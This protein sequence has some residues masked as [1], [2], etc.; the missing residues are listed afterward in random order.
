MEAGWSG[1][2]GVLH[3]ARE[4]VVVDGAVVDGGVVDGGVFDGGTLDEAVF[5]GGTSDEAVSDSET[6]DEAAFDE[7]WYNGAWFEG[8]LFQRVMAEEPS[9]SAS[10]ADA[11]AGLAPG[12]TADAGLDHGP[13]LPPDD[14]PVV[15]WPTA[16]LREALARRPGVRLAR[17]VTEAVDLDG[18]LDARRG[19][20]GDSSGGHPD[21]GSAVLSDLPDDLLGDLVVACGRLQSWAAGVQ[22]VVVAERAARE[23]HPL[24][25]SSLVAQVSGELVVTGSEASEVVVRGESGADHPAVI[26]ALRAGR[27]DTRKAQTLLRSATQLTVEERAE[28]IVRYLP[29]APSRTWRWLQSKMLA[30]AKSRH[31]ADAAAKAAV[32]RRSVQVDRAENDMAWLSA[33]LPAVDAT[34]VWGVVDDMARQLRRVPGEE[35]DLG[36][37]RADCLT[38]IVTGR[39]VPADRFTHGDGSAGAPDAFPGTRDAR[40]SQGTQGSPAGEGEADAPGTRGEAEREDCTCGGRAPVVQQVVRVIPTRPV[41]RVTVPA[42]VLLGLDDA[43]ADLAGFGPLPAEVART[44]A[45]DATWQ[46]LVT[47]PV[48]GTL[49][50]YS[51]TVYQPGSVLRRAVQ[52]RDETCTFPHCEHPAT[53]ADLDHVVPFDHD[54]DPAAQAPGTPGQTR[55]DNLQALCRRHHLLKTHGGWAVVRDPVSGI[56]TWTAPSGRTHARPPTVLDTHVE[57]DAVDPDT[58]YALSVGALNPRGGRRRSRVTTGT[59]SATDRGGQRDTDRPPF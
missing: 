35:R 44:V 32:T 34:A 38:G 42:G 29:Q 37:L 57:L 48:T 51:T 15:L 21:G 16:V 19:G 13:D 46:R 47:D 11:P 43:A 26:T 50:D 9:A 55:A 6:F 5:D 25:H 58:S 2:V 20:P 52:A 36:Q 28:A 56:T 10:C 39:L 41:V 3:G 40:P 30:F 18:E 7:D 33:Y 53:W 31:G 24:A 12:G 14:M 22:A 17:V 23:S 59:A 49:V 45:T 27:I 1:D 4:G 54:L 8:D